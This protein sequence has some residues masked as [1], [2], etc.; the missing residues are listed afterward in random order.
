MLDMIPMSITTLFTK[1]RR[2]QVVAAL[3]LLL[4]LTEVTD[5]VLMPYR[6]DILR[7]EEHSD[8]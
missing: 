1:A 3:H 5:R 2:Q 4:V 8:D 7:G 6:I